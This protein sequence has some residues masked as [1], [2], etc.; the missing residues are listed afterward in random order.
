MLR[1]KVRRAFWLLRITALIFRTIMAEDDDARSRER[2]ARLGR[3]WVP[4]HNPKREKKE[5]AVR[6]LAECPGAQQSG[7]NAFISRARSMP[8]LNIQYLGIDLVRVVVDLG[9]ADLMKAGELRSLASQVAQ[10]YHNALTDHARPMQMHAPAAMPSVTHCSSLCGLQ[11][12]L[13]EQFRRDQ[14]QH[15]HRIAR[16]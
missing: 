16:G 9:F 5:A 15:Q 11:G 14:G 1:L 3:P 10:C 13:L 2:E 4:R 12:P 8:A 7:F 6:M